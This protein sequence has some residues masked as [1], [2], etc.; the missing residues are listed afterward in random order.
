[1]RLKTISHI[2]IAAAMFFLLTAFNYEEPAPRFVGSYG[3]SE[4]DPSRINLKINTDGTFEYR[5][6]S[7]PAKAISTRGKWVVKHKKVLLKYPENAVRMHSAWS[8][9]EDGMVAKSRNGLCFYRLCR[10]AEQP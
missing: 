6:F 5:D 7:N 8:F 9:D 3:V 10:L 4:S 2:L 1:M